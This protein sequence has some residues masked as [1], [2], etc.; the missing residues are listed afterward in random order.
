MRS[1]ERC[2]QCNVGKMHVETVRTIG[3]RRTRYLRCTNKDSCKHRGKEIVHVDDLG[4]S[5]YSRQD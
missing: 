5:V 1:G 3:S 4:R 2:E